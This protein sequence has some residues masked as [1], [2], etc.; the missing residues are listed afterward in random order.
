MK[1][2]LSGLLMAFFLFPS[3]ASAQLSFNLNT[4]RPIIKANEIV[5]VGK[6]IILDA[7]QSFLPDKEVPA[8]YEWNFGDS[9][10]TD[11]GVEVVHTFSEPGEYLVEL[12]VTQGDESASIAHSVF[13]YENLI[14]L[15][16]DVTDRQESI[17]K[18]S[19]Q[20]RSEGTFINLIESYNSTTA[21]MSEEALSS[22]LNDQVNVLNSADSIVVWT[23]R[24]S[25][26]NSLTRLIREKPDNQAFLKD[27]TV[28]VIT[29]KNLKTLARIM[30]SNFDIIQPKQIVLTREYNLQNLIRS[31]SAEAFVDDLQAGVEAFEIVNADS[32]RVRPWN[33]FSYL[34][35]YMIT[36][37]IPSN[38][39]VLLLM[40]PVIATIIAFL[41]QVVGVTTF[42]LYTPRFFSPWA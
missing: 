9:T 31:P 5:Q 41:K 30:Q 14:L 42:G 12:T 36:S 3:V 27:K 18:F 24:G 11:T 13:A 20:A 38:T 32:R 10:P 39:I 16:T 28:I 40:L 26:V 19:Q 1:K 7:S 21:F 35:N 8:V 23:T 29:D 6:N 22:K 25:G 34:V 33:L 37:G 17:E 15:L 2:W 4:V